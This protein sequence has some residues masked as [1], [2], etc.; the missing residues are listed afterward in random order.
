[1]KILGKKNVFDAALDRIRYLFDEFPVVVSGVSGGKDSTVVFELTMRVARERGRL[2]LTVFWLDQEAEWTSTVDTVR[3]LMYL[4]DVKPMWMQMPMH[5]DNAASFETKFLQCWD[6]AAEADWCHE[7][8]P[9]SIKEN[10]YGTD[11]FKK[12][13]PA[14]FEKEFRGQK[15]ARGTKRTGQRSAHLARILS[16]K[17]EQPGR[18]NASATRGAAE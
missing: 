10:T 4:P 17:P 8:D 18:A 13:F 11:R 2:P 1:M 7:K 6:P 9:I 12:L 16:G 5:M 14:I 15:V 3:R